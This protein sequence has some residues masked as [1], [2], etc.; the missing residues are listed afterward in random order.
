[1]VLSILRRGNP[2]F[3]ETLR[4]SNR[5]STQTPTLWVSFILEVNPKEKAHIHNF[6]GEE[7][8][9]C[10]SGCFYYI[11]SDKRHQENPKGHLRVKAS[12]LTSPYSDWLCYILN[13][14]HITK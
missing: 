1:M 9:F 6:G 7:R 5:L 3:L 14:F 11:Q 2:F 12:K 10:H 13:T 4:K 8:H